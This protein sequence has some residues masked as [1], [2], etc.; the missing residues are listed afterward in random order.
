MDTPSPPSTPGS[1]APVTSEK[2]SPE[3]SSRSP[4]LDEDLAMAMRL[5]QEE[6]GLL[7]QPRVEFS[8]DDMD[9]HDDNFGNEKKR[10]RISKGKHAKRK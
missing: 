1:S 4:D 9:E 7:L 8:E 2:N 5:Q 3:S 6:D 10:S